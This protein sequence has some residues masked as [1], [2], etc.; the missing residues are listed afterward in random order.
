[1]KLDGHKGQSLVD[2]AFIS[3]VIRVIKPFS[4]PLWNFLYREA[5]ILGSEKSSATFALHG[6]LVLASVAKLELVSGA[7][8]G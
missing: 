2:Y 6:G 1:M 7:T 4:E 8:L 5:V 3:V